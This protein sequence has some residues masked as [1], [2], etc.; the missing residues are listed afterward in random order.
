MHAC[1]RFHLYKSDT[2]E[3]PFLVLGLVYTSLSKSSLWHPAYVLCHSSKP[4]FLF[5]TKKVGKFLDI[6]I[7]IAVKPS[8]Q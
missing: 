7:I 4:T 5:A 3:L 1:F 8:G 6:K 2:F